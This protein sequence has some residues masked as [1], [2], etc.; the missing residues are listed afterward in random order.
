MG[1]YF[2]PYA[3]AGAGYSAAVAAQLATSQVRKYIKLAAESLAY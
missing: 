2:S 1:G 3:A